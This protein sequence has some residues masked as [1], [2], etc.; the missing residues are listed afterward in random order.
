MKTSTLVLS[1]AA[2]AGVAA[3]FLHS[4]DA[5]ASSSN[6]PAGW[7]PP[8]GATFSQTPKGA[9]P[10]VQDRW[11]WRNESTGGAPGTMVLLTNHANPQADFVAYLL[12]DGA[13]AVPAILATGNTPNSGL[14]A[15]AAMAGL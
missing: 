11:Q 13:G 12:P 9:V 10:L 1:A 14:M 2:V 15:Q 6:M 3:L 4:K 5:H 7:V 8:S